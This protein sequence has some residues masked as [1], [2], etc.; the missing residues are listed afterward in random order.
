MP[1]GKVLAFGAF[2]LLHPGHLFYL[3][4]AKKLGSEL[5]VVVARDKTIEQEKGHAPVQSEKERLEIVNALKAVDR[6]VLGEKG[7]NRLSVIAREMPEVIALGHDHKIAKKEIETYLAE[8]GLSCKIVR[9][10]SFRR[11][12]FKSSLT[13]K[14]IRRGKD[15]LGLDKMSF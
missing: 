6:A 8:Q 15:E 13:R 10:P 14:K 4:K 12:K 2:D 11:K 1:E 3:E 5:V 9:L 7:G